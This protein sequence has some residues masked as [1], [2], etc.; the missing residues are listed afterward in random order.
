MRNCGENVLH[1]STKATWPSEAKGG[2]S[3][4]H[5]VTLSMPISVTLSTKCLFQFV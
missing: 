3:K 1:S 5:K 4:I 2:R